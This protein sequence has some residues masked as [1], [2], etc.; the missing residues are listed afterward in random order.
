M[1]LNLGNAQRSQGEHFEQTWRQCRGRGACDHA[2]RKIA[3]KS[4]GR[5]R[6]LGAQEQ[7]VVCWDFERET[8]GEGPKS[9]KSGM[10]SDE[11]QY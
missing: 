3:L 11:G 9:Q 6:S 1:Y 2:D 10:T 8:L 5:Y 4:V 7:V